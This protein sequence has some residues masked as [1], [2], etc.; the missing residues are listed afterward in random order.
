[1]NKETVKITGMTCAACAARVEKVVNKME[2][3]NVHRLTLPPKTCQLNIMR[4]RHPGKKS[5]KPL[6]KPDTVP[7]KFPQ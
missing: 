6:K 4:Q 7:W 5:M 1:M 2:G 3:I